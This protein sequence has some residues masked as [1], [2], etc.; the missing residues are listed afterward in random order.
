MGWET[1]R[2]LAEEGANVVVISRNPG[3]ISAQIYDLASHYGVAIT[4]IAAD[5]SIAG[6]VEAA[7]AEAIERFGHLH[8]LA[9]TNHWMGMT[10]DFVGI[11]DSEW[12]QYFQNSLM[13]AVRAARVILPHM[14]A[15]GGGSLVLTTAYSSRAP[16]AYIPAYAAFKAALNNLVKSLAK[17]YGQAGVRVNGV[18]PGAIRTGRYDARLESLFKQRPGI[19]R[20]EA[21]RIMLDTLDMKVALER[22]GDPAEV[23]ELIVFF[24]SKRA[25]YMTGVIANVDGG[26]DF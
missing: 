16:K 12:E 19:A 21:E 26:T 17:T 5:A 13:A 10:R 4:G 20:A 23:A 3:V 6:N 15:Q 22:I 18:A 7:I 24:L 9:V 8:G 25:A 14:A 1:V 11:D 2:L